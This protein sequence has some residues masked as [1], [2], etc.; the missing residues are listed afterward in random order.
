MLD[1]ALVELAGNV[2]TFAIAVVTGSG[3]ADISL[4]NDV[5]QRNRGRVGISHDIADRREHAIGKVVD[6][7]V[8]PHVARRVSHESVSERQDLE[9]LIIAVANVALGIPGLLEKVIQPNAGV[10][11]MDH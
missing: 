8:G 4:D 11:R 3:V 2:G 5:A 10:L 1:T 9:L 6:Q 7:R